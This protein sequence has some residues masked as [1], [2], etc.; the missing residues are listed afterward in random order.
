MPAARIDGTKQTTATPCRTWGASHTVTRLCRCQY[1]IGRKSG[2]RGRSACSSPAMRGT[3][4]TESLDQWRAS[5]TLRLCYPT[6]HNQR[7]VGEPTVQVR[8]APIWR[9]WGSNLSRSAFCMSEVN[10]RDDNRQL[11]HDQHACG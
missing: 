10:C 2:T 9:V 3:T 8:Q 6:L 1:R 4:R 7:R 5:A 11:P